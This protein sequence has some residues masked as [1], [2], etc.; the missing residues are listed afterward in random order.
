MIGSTGFVT[1]G[2]TTCLPCEVIVKVVQVSSPEV[3]AN[4]D[5]CSQMLQEQDNTIVN[6]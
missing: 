6:D 4:V 3:G 1:K 5:P 2:A